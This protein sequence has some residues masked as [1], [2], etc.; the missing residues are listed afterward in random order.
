MLTLWALQMLVDD[1]L[2]YR[3]WT[4]KLPVVDAD[5]IAVVDL[6][7]SLG[8]DIDMPIRHP[9]DL[10]YSSDPGL[11]EYVL[12][13]VAKRAHLLI[14]RRMLRQGADVHVTSVVVSGPTSDACVVMRW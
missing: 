13:H 8:I 11:D 10:R 6:M 12:H 7:L 1:R 3:L 4:S 9:D 2:P 14:V 5:G